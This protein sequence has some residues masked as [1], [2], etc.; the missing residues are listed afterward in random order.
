MLRISLTERVTNEAVLQRA[1][2]DRYLMKIIRQR[3]LRLFEHVKRQKQLENV[4][5]MGKI[6]G[7]RGRGRLRIK[8]VDT[9]ARVVGGAWH[10][11]GTVA[12]D[13]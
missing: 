5:V 6:E 9:L 4:F 12:T 13:D 2:A 3:Q 10:N 11:F 8:L 1:K 7:R